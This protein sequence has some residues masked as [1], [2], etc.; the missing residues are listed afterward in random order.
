MTDTV[1]AGSRKEAWMFFGMPWWVWVL[2]V[3]GLAVFVPIKAYFLK[4]FFAKKPEEPAEDE[5][6]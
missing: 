4:K 5:E 6:D 1:V 2:I 3:A